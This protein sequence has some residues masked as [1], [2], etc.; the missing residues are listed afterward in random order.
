MTTDE[1]DSKVDLA[2]VKMRVA[3]AGFREGEECEHCGGSGRV[4][5]GRMLIHSILGGMGAD[6]EVDD[7]LAQLDR[8]TDVR[9]SDMGPL[10]HDL[11]VTVDGRKYFY[12]VKRP[13]IDPPLD[14]EAT[15]HGTYVMVE[16]TIYQRTALDLKKWTQAWMR[17]SV[18]PMAV[19]GKRCRMKTYYEVGRLPAGAVVI[20]EEEAKRIGPVSLEAYW[21]KVRAVRPA[22][23]VT[24]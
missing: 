4:A 2:D 18:P 13:K 5:G 20:S 8:A 1:Q 3:F 21:A 17:R 11:V 12:Q 9:W 10:G 16:G 24:S 7:V 19:P 23:E 6:H 22:A 15:P 14:S